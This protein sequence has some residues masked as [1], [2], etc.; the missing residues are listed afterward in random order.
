MADKFLTQSGLEHFLSKCKDTFSAKTHT[1]DYIEN[2]MKGVANGVASLDSSGL[3]P[4]SQLPPLTDDTKVT[5]TPS[6]STS[7]YPILA[8]ATANAS[9]TAT[10]TSIFAT[11]IKITPSTNT[12]TASGGFVGNLTGNVTGTIESATKDGDGNI[13]A[14]TYATK[15]ELGD[16]N[17]ILDSINGEIV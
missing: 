3:V 5:Q 16:I 2:T 17:S 1:H 12:I 9:S 6:T 4:T 8:S 11:G 7:S 10:T 13:I 14:S 15:A